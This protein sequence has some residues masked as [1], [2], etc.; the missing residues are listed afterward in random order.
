[1]SIKCEVQTRKNNR[2]MKSLQADIAADIRMAKRMG[3]LG[4]GRC[5]LDVYYDGRLRAEIAAAMTGDDGTV[6]HARRMLAFIARCNGVGVVKVD[7]KKVSL[8][9]N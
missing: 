6:D 2:A 7:V 1:M 9:G 3:L 8:L 5:R 4:V